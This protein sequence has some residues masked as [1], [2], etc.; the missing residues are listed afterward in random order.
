MNDDSA[1]L[2]AKFV[3]CALMLVVTLVLAAIPVVS[4][5]VSMVGRH[6]GW[7]LGPEA[8]K[9]FTLFI[10]ALTGLFWLSHLMCSAAL[11]TGAKP[12]SPMLASPAPNLARGDQMLWT[13]GHDHARWHGHWAS[14]SVGIWG[15]R[16]D[17]GVIA[18][19]M[20]AGT[21]ELKGRLSL[22]GRWF[23]RTGPL[24]RLSIDALGHMHTH[25]K[26]RCTTTSARK[27]GIDDLDMTPQSMPWSQMLLQRP[28]AKAALKH[29][30]NNPLGVDAML[31]EFC[32]IHLRTTFES[33]KPIAPTP[34][35]FE[36][37]LQALLTLLETAEDLPNQGA[38]LTP[39][40]HIHTAPTANKPRTTPHLLA[41][42]IHVGLAWLICAFCTALKFAYLLNTPA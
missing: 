38:V 41:A 35:Q 15:R 8:E 26:W 29:L 16:H 11:T 13:L 1:A 14:R 27:L 22:R 6:Q 10:F 34:D 18:T 33:S 28:K 17:P 23:W 5:V 36:A 37:T 3:G 39:A 7:A 20:S 24:R 4:V 25:S 40:D 42:I 30:R 2:G 12:P 31:I 21:I 19:P 9:H 32:P